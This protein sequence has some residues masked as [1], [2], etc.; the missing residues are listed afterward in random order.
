MK[1]AVIL[2]G[3]SSEHEISLQSGRSVAEGLRD[4]GHEVIEVLIGR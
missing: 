2:G 3:R 1:V 4:A